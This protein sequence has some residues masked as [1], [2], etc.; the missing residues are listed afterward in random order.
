MPT[1]QFRYFDPGQSAPLWTDADAFA[2]TLLTLFLD[3]YGTEGLAWH[4]DTI[5]MEIEHDLG[6][7]MPP[8][9][10]ER[11]MTAISLLTTDGFFTSVPDFVYGCV[12]LNGHHVPPGVFS[13]ADA[14][15]CAWG[16]TE[17]MLINPPEDRTPFS[18]EI[19]SYIGKVL[20]DEGILVPPDV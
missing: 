4:P 7:I 20:D 6:I 16:V 12:V 1:E 18:D 17:A 19:C 9:N 2:T 5:S 13:P 14:A 10:Y 15:D 3:T 11:L 8:D